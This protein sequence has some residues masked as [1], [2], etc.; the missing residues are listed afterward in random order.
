MRRTN[1]RRRGFTLVEMIASTAIMATIA[2]SGFVV[3]RTANNAWVRHRDDANKRREAFAV[4]E[5]IARRVRQATRVTAITTAVD[6]AGALTVLMPSGTN[7]M[8]SRNSGTNQ[9]LYGTTSPTNL[10]ATGITEATFVGFKADGTTTTTETDLIHAIR[11]TVKYTLSRPA[12]AVTE[13]VSRT[14]WLRSW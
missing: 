5:H 10:L 13:T 6:T 12:G 8:W 3:V 2:T 11:C 9:V 7:S 14:A 1:A 4:L